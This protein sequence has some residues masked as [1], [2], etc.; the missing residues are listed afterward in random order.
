MEA[1]IA[2][3]DVVLTTRLH[4]LVLALKNGVPAV[5]VD[6]IAGGSKVKRQAEAIGWPVVLTADAL[7]DEELNEAFDYCLTEEARAKA[8]ECCEQA[9]E[10]IEEVRGE[11][12]RALRAPGGSRQEYWKGNGR[13][14]CG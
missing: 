1:L 13:R 14:T 5:A 3:M 10:E 4:G 12:L 6:A 7:K 11:F 9:R 2:D 8:G